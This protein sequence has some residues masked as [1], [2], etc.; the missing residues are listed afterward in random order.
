M[1]AEIPYA[2][3]LGLVPASTAHSGIGL[4][5]SR[6]V[7][8]SKNGISPGSYRRPSR[9]SNERFSNMITTM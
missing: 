6:P 3:C 9:L 2:T 1:S 4:L 8:P 7:T 5:S